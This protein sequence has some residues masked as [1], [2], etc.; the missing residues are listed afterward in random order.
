M[1]FPTDTSY[2]GATTIGAADANG[3]VTLL[4]CASA[5]LSPNSAVTIGEGSYLDLR[6]GNQTIASLAG[7]GMVID[8]S[9]GTEA[10]LTISGSASTTFSGQILDVSDGGQM[11]LVKSGSS[12]LTLASNYSEIVPANVSAF[13]GGTTITSGTLAL[14]SPTALGSGSLV[15]NGGTLNLNGNGA[16]VPGLSGTGGAITN[17]SGSAA[18]LTVDDAGNGTTEYGGTLQNGS[19]ALHLILAGPATMMLSGANGGFAGSTTVDSGILDLAGPLGGTLTVYSSAQVIGTYSPLQATVAYPSAGPAGADFQVTGSA[20]DRIASPPSNLLLSWQVFDASNDLLDSGSGPDFDFTPSTTGT[21]SVSLVATDSDATSPTVTHNFTVSNSSSMAEIQGLPAGDVA[22]QSTTTPISITAGVSGPAAGNTIAY[23]WTVTTPSGAS[24]TGSQGT[25]TFTPSQVGTYTIALSAETSGATICPST[26]TILVLAPPATP[27]GFMTSLVSANEVDLEW[28]SDPTDLSGY[29]LSQSSDVESTWSWSDPIQVAAGVNDWAMPGPFN[30]QGNYEFEIQAINLAGGPSAPAMLDVIGSP[31]VAASSDTQVGVNWQAL[32]GNVTSYAL[33]RSAD[34]GSTWTTICTTSGATSF[35]DTGLTGGTTYEYQIVAQLSYGTS[36]VSAPASVTTY[37]SAPSGLTATFVSMDEIDLSWQSNSPMAGG[38]QVQQS[39]DGGET[40]PTLPAAG[41]GATSYVAPGPFTPGSTVEFRVSA[42]DDSGNAGPASNTASASVPAG[43]PAAP[44]SLT[45]AVESPYQ[46][47]LTWSDGGDATGYIVQRQDPSS[48]SWDDIAI[49]T[50]GSTTSYDDVLVQPETG[51]SYQVV[52]T[53]AAGGSTPSILVTAA[54]SL[55]PPSDLEATVL[56][57][58]Q[59]ELD[60]LTDSTLGQD[61]QI[62]ESTSAGDPSTWSQAATVS[63]GTTTAVISGSFT[64]GAT[65]YFAVR[66]EGG[67]AVS[68]PDSPYSNTASVTIPGLPAAP[69]DV[70]AAAA[71]TTAIDVTWTSASGAASY[72]VQRETSGNPAWTTIATPTG[73]AT[74]YADSSVIPGETYFY[75]VIASNSNGQSAAELANGGGSSSGVSTSNQILPPTNLQVEGDADTGLTVSWSNQSPN[76][77]QTTVELTG[78]SGQT[79][80]AEAD[81]EAEEVDFAATSIT[82]GDWEVHVYSVVGVGQSSTVSETYS[83]P[84]APPVD[85]FQTFDVIEGV[86]TQINL[87]QDV[88]DTGGETTSYTVTTGPANGTLSSGSGSTFTYTSDAGFVGV[89]T[90]QYTASVGGQVGDTGAVEINVTPDVVIAYYSPACTLDTSDPDEYIATGQLCGSDLSGLPR[91]Y[92]V[93]QGSVPDGATLQCSP[94][95]HFT[96][97]YPADENPDF[98]FTCSDGIATSNHASADYDVP[99]FIILTIGNPPSGYTGTAPAAVEPEPY[100][101]YDALTAADC[102]GQLSAWVHGLDINEVTPTDNGNVQMNNDGSFIYKANANFIGEDWYTYTFTNTAG[103]TSPLITVFFSVTDN[104]ISNNSLNDSGEAESNITD[105]DVTEMSSPGMVVP[106]DTAVNSDGAPGY[107]DGYGLYGNDDAADEAADMMPITIAVPAGFN[108]ET[109]QMQISYVASNPADVTR[110]GAGTEQSPYEYQLLGDA[111]LRLWTTNGARSDQPFS[112]GGSYVAPD[113]YSASDLEDLISLNQSATDA[114]GTLTFYVERVA[115]STDTAQNTISVSFDTDGSGNFSTP[116][117]VYQCDPPTLDVDSLDVSA[118]LPDEGSNA[119]FSP[120]VAQ[121]TNQAQASLSPAGKIIVVNDVMVDGV[122]AFA[123]F[124]GESNSQFVPMIVTLPQGV[125]TSEANLTFAY[126]GSDPS[127]IQDSGSSPDESYL[128]APGTLR[129]WTVDA[130]EARNPA[131]VT[132]SSPG[133]YI[134]PNIPFP[135]GKLEWTNIPGTTD[136]E[137]TVYIEAVRASQTTG[138]QTITATVSMDGTATNL[139][140]GAVKLTAVQDTVPDYTTSGLAGVAQG[141][142][143]GNPMANAFSGAVRLSD[144]IVNYATTDF[145]VPGVGFPRTVSRLWTDQPGLVVN[146]SFGNG[147]IMTQLPYLIQATGSIIAVVDG[148]PFYFDQVSANVYKERFFGLEQLTF[149]SASGQYTFVDTTGT[150]IVFNGF[151]IQNDNDPA[152]G[153]YER[154]AMKSVT[155]ADGNTMT[156][157]KYDYLGNVAQVTAGS[158]VFTYAYT[159]VTNTTEELNSVTQA[160]SGHVVAKAQYTYYGANDPNG[161]AGD[162]KQVRVWTSS[163]GTAP[164]QEIAGSYYRY[165]VANLSSPTDNLQDAVTGPAYARLVAAVFGPTAASAVPVLGSTQS[166]DSADVTDYADQF[167]YNSQGG[168]NLQV[169]VGAGPSSVGSPFAQGYFSYSYNTV[170][171]TGINGWSEETTI[172][173]SGG[174]AALPDDTTQLAYTNYAGEPMLS[175]LTDGNDPANSALDGKTWNTFFA[176]DQ[177]GRLILTAQPSAL[178]ADDPDDGIPDLLD[179]GSNGSYLLMNAATGLI[180]G[181][182]YYTVTNSAQGAVAGYVEDNYVQQGQQTSTKDLQSYYQ[183]HTLTGG[184]IS[185]H[186]VSEQLVY[187]SATSN[188]ADPSERPTSFSYTNTGLHIS[189]MVASLPYVAAAQGAL[190]GT[191]TIVTDYYQNGLVQ[192]IVDADNYESSYVYDN[193][194]GAVTSTTSVVNQTTDA[195]IVNSALDD[196]LGRTT[197]TTDGNG[198]STTV[199]YS[200][201]LLQSTVTITP[202]TGPVQVVVTNTGAGTITTKQTVP[203]GTMQIVSEVWVDYAGRTLQ[204]NT[205]PKSNTTYTTFDAYNNSGQLYWTQDAVGT[206][207]ETEFD[208]LGRPTETLVGVN[209]DGQNY[210]DPSDASLTETESEQFDNNGVG[211]GNVTLTTE[212]AQ[213]PASTQTTGNTQNY[214]SS[215]LIYSYYDWQDQLVATNNGLQ[216]TVN[217]LDSLGEVT[218]TQVYDATQLPTSE[219]FTSGVAQPPLN[220][221]ALRAQT[222]NKFDNQGDVYET[223]QYSVNPT[224]GAAGGYLAADYYHDGR[225]DTVATVSPGGLVT[226]EAFDGMGDMTLQQ[227][228]NAG[229][230][231]GTIGTVIQSAATQYDGNRNAVFVA[232]SQWNGAT[233]STLTTYVANWYN[234][235][236]QVTATANYGTNANASGVITPMGGQPGTPPTSSNTVIVQQPNVTVT[237]ELTTYQYD[238]GGFLSQMTDPTGLKT[239]YSNDYLGRATTVVVDSAAGATPNQLNQVTYYAYDGLNRQESVTVENITPTSGSTP[240]ASETIYRYG[241]TRSFSANTAYPNL[242]SAINDNDLLSETIYPDGTSQWDYYNALGEVTTQTERDTSEHQYIYDLAGR[243]IKDSVAN[244]GQNS[245][246]DTS[247]TALG[248]TYNA[249]GQL[250]LATSFGPGGPGG[251]VNQVKNV[252][253]GL[254]N[255]VTQYQAQ[256]AA[257]NGSTPAAQYQYDTEYANSGNYS[258]LTG[259]TYV[260]GTQIEYGYDESDLDDSISRIDSVSEGSQTLET[261]EYLGLSTVIGATL[262]EPG[263][264]ESVTLDNFGNVGEISWND[265]RPAVVDIA[266]RY[267]G[268]GDILS[269]QDLIAADAGPTQSPN[270]GFDQTYSYDAMH[271]LTGYQQGSLSSSSNTIN[272]QTGGNSWTLDSLGNRYGGGVYGISYSTASASASGSYSVAGNTTMVVVDSGRTVTLKYDAW[273]RVVQSVAQGATVNNPGGPPTPGPTTTTKYAYDALGRLITTTNV[274]GGGS[275]TGT[276]TYYDG[277]NP[278]VVQNQVGQLMMTYVWSP[279]DG[280][281]ILRD[282]VAAKLGVAAN[283]SGGVIQRLYPLTDGLGSIVAVAAAY[284]PDPNHPGQLIETGASNAVQ[285]RYVYTADGSPTALL[286][287]FQPITVN[288]ATVAASQLGWTWFYRGEQ[289]IQTNPDTSTAPWRGLYVTPSGVWYDPVHAVTL[290]PNPSAYGDPHSNPYQLSNLEALGYAAPLI[291]GAA[292]T[293][294]TGGIGAPAVAALGLGGAATFGFS[295]YVAGNNGPQVARDAVIGGIS[296]AAGFYAGQLARAGAG[297]LARSLGLTCATGGGAAGGF[298][299]GAAEGAAF[300]GTQ[301][302]VSTALTTGNISQAFAAAGPAALMGGAIG[303]PLGAIFHQVCFVAGTQVVLEFLECEDAGS[304]TANVRL[305]EGAVS[306]VPR[307]RCRTR[308]IEEI[309]AGELIASRDQNEPFGPVVYSRVDRIYRR[310]ADHLRILTVLGFAGCEQTLKTTDDHPYYVDGKDWVKALELE[311]GD[312]FFGR[313]G[314][315]GVLLAGHREEHPEGI[316]VYNLRVEGTHT[317]FVREQGVDAEPVWVHNATYEGMDQRVGQVGYNETD[318]SQAVVAEREVQGLQSSWRNGAAVEYFDGQG[319]QVKVMFSERDVGHSETLLNNWLQDNSIS[320]DQV[321]RWYSERQPCNTYPY[322][323][324]QMLA[325]TYPNAYV[326]WSIPFRTAAEKAKATGVLLDNLAGIF[327]R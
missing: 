42:L 152:Q 233:G 325:A 195:I 296:T 312:V 231:P 58:G 280:R 291:I 167:Y 52:A 287:N 300:F 250:T 138:D 267:D 256:S 194:T 168:V 179:K 279:L 252:Y 248:D 37:Q 133:D 270:M 208:G 297:L 54:T 118:G 211:D 103:E 243:Q 112:D 109:G 14:G 277:N 207:T 257:A 147:E 182:D 184:S 203:G 144:G 139:P 155:D 177:Q 48:A 66:K 190:G 69:T 110:T 19:S 146:P 180:E 17:N 281:M 106:P 324:D 80:S 165:A 108:T 197:Q 31:T 76:V 18:T 229:S 185:I 4:P 32:P 1:L 40:W 149:N 72:E 148:Q 13:S 46:I 123:D 290:Q 73:S 23:S 219:S 86:A 161:K 223:D 70:T 62:V 166:F 113:V 171:E 98:T 159:L 319:L 116:E 234:A 35:T 278:I 193:L 156:V 176:Y 83:V 275:N 129:L 49:I 100:Q 135:A 30:R 34:D 142:D 102:V 200:D 304:L 222:V 36:S 310:L 314:T 3:W 2:S 175:E 63:T 5:A 198:F 255:L 214:G 39:T 140:I 289:W 202:P 189:Q 59:I 20:T 272:N 43:L 164:L 212:Y 126:S 153:M 262:P 82:F 64:D 114:E 192:S 99:D 94:N 210:L 308:S 119:Q 136:Q 137:A 47:N 220:A 183:Y 125:N 29:L 163:S 181:T 33:Q 318:L 85:G 201:G 44:S 209:P 143:G 246:L 320:P 237:V 235:L 178:T 187:T 50:S 101:Y 53:D 170:G 321:T 9:V 71:S 128:P 285:E 154:G 225:G 284:I 226:T 60:W 87:S 322:F 261:D 91:T 206:V 292:V 67:S 25:F 169:I 28:T 45:A 258:D 122:P 217:T 247:V 92:T 56:S 121:E 27:A 124:G 205:Y 21:Y 298:L 186:P 51:Y 61:F 301:A 130:G 221:A 260:G 264:T 162:L 134:A 294:A 266:Y 323:C 236:N 316:W 68:L 11:A 150:Q 97:T 7:A 115:D 151:A 259:V 38:Y 282:A 232:T 245:T 79:V 253:D 57:G 95:G 218:A 227:T 127:N 174:T 104:V 313:D 84:G 213:V 204:T 302:F 111:A 22:Q 160:R 241:S 199:A 157:T 244:W 75:Q 65:Y 120:A 173:S 265:G 307:V 191:G 271:R 276:Q 216:F 188:M 131:A 132:A 8:D 303:G 288:G 295:S 269:R 55:L 249:L 6:G 26:Q 15:V 215:V 326:T 93:D 158:D 240:K 77:G 238:A 78:P 88:N 24:L 105:Q 96:E 242:T 224:S 145:S 315:C 10:T 117:T 41:S 141:A 254:G 228:G 107:A 305:A 239:S 196:L 274:V 90:F 311:V 268:A 283:T 286:P 16:S 74:A 89:D 317:F 230:T 172:T 12:T 273:G 81:G 299:V 293:L 309:I 263:I 327:G 306:T 251:I